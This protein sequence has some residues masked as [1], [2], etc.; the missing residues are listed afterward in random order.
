[1]EAGFEAVADAFAANFDDA[2]EVGAACCVYRGGQPVVELWGGVA[3]VSSGR[4]WER[5]TPVLVFSLTKGVTAVCIHLLVE[6]GLLDLDRP[7]A[8]YWPEFGAEGKDQIPVRW[9]LSH[10][11]GV[12]AIDAPVTLEDIVGWHG[13]V[14]AVAAQAPN[15]EP[16]TDHGYHAR[17]FGWILGEVIRRI[18]GMSPGTFLANEIASPLGLDMWLGLPEAIESRV[19]PIVRPDPPADPEVQALME[20]LAASDS[21]LTRVMSGPSNLFAYDERWNERPLHEAEMPS[22]N[23]VCTAVAAARLYA[24]TV[25]EVDGIRLLAPSTVDAARVVQ[26]D[27]T[28]CVIGVD[29]RFALGFGVAPFLSEAC[30]PSAFGHPGAG[31]SL[32]FGDQ[33]VELGFG[34]VMNQM[35]FDPSQPDVRATRLVR[36]VYDSL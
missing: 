34:Y 17:T 27:G 6:R 21:L 1:V 16:G 25:G 15:W 24:A 13:V 23:A 20:A 7:V 33:D 32:A 11:A 8:S 28:D 9:V 14:A 18:T 29:S 3:D 2:G 22:S 4:V 10:R 30:P 12:A 26:S 36:A 5:D 31:G 35:K 19:A